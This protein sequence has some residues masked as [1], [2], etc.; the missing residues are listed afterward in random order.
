MMVVIMD[1]NEYQKLA[2]KSALY[3]NIN[4]SESTLNLE[5]SGNI[6]PKA[7]EHLWYPVIGLSG[8]VGEVLNKI[9]KYW[10]DGKNVNVEELKGELGDV[11]WYLSTVATELDLKRDDIASY[12]ITKLEDRLKRNKIAGSADNR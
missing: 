10:R 5:K 12:N 7:L 4:I 3:K 9:Q 1:F 8:E 6:T 11:L 2:I